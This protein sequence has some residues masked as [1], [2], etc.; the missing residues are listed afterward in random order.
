MRGPCV[1]PD[2]ISMRAEFSSE[3][4]RN[5][6]RGAGSRHA[7]P[8]CKIA[9]RWNDSTSAT[10]RP[11]AGKVRAA[12]LFFPLE[13]GTEPQMKPAAL[14]LGPLLALALGGCA[15]LGLQPSPLS[16]PIASSEVDWARK[17]GS[18]TVTGLAELT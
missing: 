16:T 14:A 6:R 11:Q 1:P 4:R 17:S 13:N 15:Q 8:R 12:T 3:A 18:N 2:G 10:K 7:A 9:L 5:K